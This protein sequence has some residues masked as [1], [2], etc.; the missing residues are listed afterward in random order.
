MTDLNTKLELF[1]A[2]AGRRNERRNFLRFAGGSALAIGG[3]TLLSACGSDDSDLAP[4]PT[5]TPTPAPA[6]TLN[7][8]DILNFALNLEYLEAQFY[9]FAAF[10][11]G[12][13]ASLLTGTGT[14]GAV[15]G[16]AQVPF[17][18]TVVREY[19][20]EI[21]IDEVAHVAF[22]RTALGTA[23]VAQPAIDISAGTAAAPGAFTAAA[24][25]AGV[26]G[27]TGV[28]N[29]YAD[30][31]SF[32]L[33]AYI[34][35]DVGISAYKG[36]AALIA[37]KTYLEAAAGILAA[38]AYHAGLIRTILYRKGLD[39]PSLRTV[40]GQI[41]DARDSLDGT[42][43]NSATGVI[44]DIDQGITGSD[45]TVSNIVPTDANG[46]AYSRSVA[47]VH[48]IAYLTN[49]AKIG[50]GFFPNGTNNRTDSLRTSGANA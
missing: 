50:G 32:L 19:A 21:A 28:F 8:A 38:E 24:R 6:A 29:P 44:G 27:S 43:T 30:D 31:N 26:V 39:T 5:P 15:T 42:V 3:A 4:G 1:D 48:N 33:G 10:G 23:A 16:G 12:L 25:A 37:N 45:P 18:D 11:V 22:L 7:D 35:E 46:L 47:Q 14:Q 41:S 9:A 49:T 40:A 20:R 2:I 17:Q 34:F 13:N 36:A